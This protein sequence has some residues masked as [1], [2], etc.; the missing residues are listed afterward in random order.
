MTDPPKE[1]TPLCDG[2]EVAGRNDHTRQRN[3]MAG[4]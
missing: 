1:E 3:T 4:C 2:G